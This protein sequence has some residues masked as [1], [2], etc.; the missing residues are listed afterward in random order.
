MMKYFRLLTAGLMLAMFSGADQA[1]AASGNSPSKSPSTAAHSASSKSRAGSVHKSA[2]TYMKQAASKGYLL[3]R[4]SKN[5]G[6]ALRNSL[7]KTLPATALYKGSMKHTI[8][9]NPAGAAFFNY[10]FP[11]WMVSHSK[12]FSAEQKSMLQTVGI[13][14]KDIIQPREKRYW[15]IIVENTAAKK[16][17]SFRKSNMTACTKEIASKWFI[18]G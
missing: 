14:E 3:K 17:F 13:R 6:T 12:G 5:G 16:P 2:R 4:S 8:D 7:Q 15:L 9:Q 1:E 18:N 11:Y 10:Y